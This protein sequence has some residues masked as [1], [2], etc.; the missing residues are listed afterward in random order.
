MYT[1]HLLN[2]MLGPFKDSEIYLLW[3]HI[4]IISYDQFRIYLCATSSLT[5]FFDY[6]PTLV[7]SVL[8][9]DNDM[10]YGEGTKDIMNLYG[11]YLIDTCCS[12][13]A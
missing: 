5:M 3:A 4:N 13:I 9:F 8:N 2:L 7:F 11:V 1:D 10:I 12:V 6:V